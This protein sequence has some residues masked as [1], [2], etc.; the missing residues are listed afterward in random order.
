MGKRLTPPKD[1]QKLL[2]QIDEGKRTP[3]QVNDFVNVLDNKIKER[4]QNIKKMWENSKNKGKR[5]FSA[6][7]NEIFKLA[8]DQLQESEMNMLISQGK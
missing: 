8:N 5:I 1:V 2:K 6:T 4:V 3:E 7:L